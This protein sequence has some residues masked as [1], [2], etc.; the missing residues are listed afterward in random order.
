MERS[1]TN[2]PR[3]TRLAVIASG[4]LVAAAS[5]WVG[6]YY[7]SR[8]HDVPPFPP[9]TP[10]AIRPIVGV[11]VTPQVSRAP[12]SQAPGELPSP[13]RNLPERPSFHVTLRLQKEFHEELGQAVLNELAPVFPQLRRILGEEPYERSE[14]PYQQIFFQ[15]LEA[16]EKAPVG[17]RPALL[18]AA[19]LVGSHLG[20]DT[21]GMRDQLEKVCGGLRKDLARFGITMK[22]DELGGGLYYPHDLLWRIWRDY[23]ETPWGQRAFVFILDHGWDTS[24]TCEKGEDQ[25]R[26]VIRQGEAFLQQR[27]HSP[28]RGAVTLLVAEAYASWWS[29]SNEPAVSDMSAYVD[30]NK[31]QEGAEEARIKAI[32][33]FE[34]VLQLAP[35]T[36]LS[37]FAQQALPPLREQQVLDNYRFFCVYD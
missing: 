12:F 30:P 14:L 35:G 18:F 5:V 10:P 16:A 4:F 29:L 25:T 34:Q 31:F 8:L 7:Y 20:C 37:E 28:Y 13:P 17:R 26:E 32:G 1:S 2:R 22:N 19:D 21:S 9:R 6:F 24:A 23:P 36:K 11:L 27:P 15:L 33:Y 3:K